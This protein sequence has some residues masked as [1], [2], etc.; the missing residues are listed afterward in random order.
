[1]SLPLLSPFIIHNHPVTRRCVADIRPLHKP[2]NTKSVKL[3]IKYDLQGLQIIRS[4]Y[5]DVHQ[6]KGSITPSEQ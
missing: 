6:L 1:L 4:L 5:T 2:N 3:E